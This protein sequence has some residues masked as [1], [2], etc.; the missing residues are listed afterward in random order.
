M[1]NNDLNQPPIDITDIP[2]QTIVLDKFAPGEIKV[3]KHV[4]NQPWPVMVA[5]LRH[6][7]GSGSIQVDGNFMGLLI[8]E[9]SDTSKKWEI[10]L[11]GYPEDTLKQ[12][13][14]ILEKKNKKN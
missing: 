11:I 4:A 3:F 13:N 9:T 7:G 8:G 6:R 12:Y 14:E 1:F 2:K 5:Q 10:L